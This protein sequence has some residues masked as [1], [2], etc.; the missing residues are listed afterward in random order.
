MAAPQMLVLMIV[1][2]QMQ[3]LFTKQFLVETE[4]DIPNDGR[5]RGRGRFQNKALTNDGAQPKVDLNAMFRFERQ[6]DQYKRMHDGNETEKECTRDCDWGEDD[7]VQ[8]YDWGF[9]YTCNSTCPDGNKCLIWPEGSTGLCK[10]TCSNRNDCGPDQLCELTQELHGIH[11][12]DID[13]GVGVCVKNECSSSKKCP[14]FDGKFFDF[15]PGKGKCIEGRCYYPR[16]G[17]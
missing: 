11:H 7:E 8:V 1:A 14:D 15:P 3:G 12:Y 10:K 6:E 13:E 17:G 5:A 9:N 4:D 2:L 16:E